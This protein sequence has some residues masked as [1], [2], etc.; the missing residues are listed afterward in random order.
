ML[1]SAALKV[2]NKVGDLIQIRILVE[3]IEDLGGQRL[4][5]HCERNV[6]NDAVVL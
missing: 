2:I 4:N 6:R 1:G 3:R 5:N